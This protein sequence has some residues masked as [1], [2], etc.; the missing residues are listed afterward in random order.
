MTRPEGIDRAL[1]LR[2]VAAGARPE[3][4]RSDQQTTATVNAAGAGLPWGLYVV[5]RTR[6][7]RPPTIRAFAKPD[8]GPRISD[9]PSTVAI[10]M[11]RA[12]N[13]S[14]QLIRYPPSRGMPFSS[15]W[16]LEETILP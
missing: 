13:F 12:E 4:Q 6:V 3:L 10:G 11:H 16:L 9:G 15:A 2:P 8:A 7:G 14:D 1:T 5:T